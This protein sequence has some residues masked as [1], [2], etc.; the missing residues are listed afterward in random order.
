MRRILLFLVL[1]TVTLLPSAAQA[2]EIS[3]RIGRQAQLTPDGSITFQVW[4]S[5]EL[6]GTPDLREGLAG[7][8]QARTGASAEGGLSPDIV[9]DGVERAY[10]AGISLISEEE[11]ARGPATA[12]ATVIACN[13]VGANQVCVQESAR[14]RVIVRGRAAS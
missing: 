9:C 3:V 10:T 4:V 1:S 13:T 8:G 11:F 6:P 2:Q 12:H 14:R 5:C 7:A